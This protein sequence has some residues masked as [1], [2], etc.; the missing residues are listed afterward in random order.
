MTDTSQIAGPR[1]LVGFTRIVL[2]VF[3][4]A[5]ILVGVAT[6][7]GSTVEMAT[8][9]S[10]GH[11][12][13]TL[14]A[15]KALP[16]AATNCAGCTL[17]GTFSSAEVSVGGLSGEVVGFALAAGIATGLTD[18]ALSALVAILAWRLLRRGF[19]R[20]TLS[21]TVSAAGAVLTIGG[22]IS[23][24]GVAL[25]GGLAASE[26]N[27]HGHDY[28]PLAGTFDPTLVVFGIVLLL[29]G[30]AFEYGARLQKETEG[31]V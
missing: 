31:L 23:Q 20:R 29:V 4:V 25:A 11:I 1:V 8:G 3:F 9:L 13:L 6:L 5:A 24:G 26:I 27:G 17:T 21:N 18:I 14:V 30:L 16:P 7:V 15:E 22:M 2:W 10:S 12:P 19:F 28:W